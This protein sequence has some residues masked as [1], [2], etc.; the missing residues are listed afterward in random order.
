M[1]NILGGGGAYIGYRGKGK[2]LQG[3]GSISAFARR[4]EEGEARGDCPGDTPESAA[5][6]GREI[7]D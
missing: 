6:E 5:A 1:G 4:G 3:Q 2:R 7:T